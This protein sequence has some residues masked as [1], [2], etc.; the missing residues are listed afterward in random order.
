MPP[1]IYDVVNFRVRMTDGTYGGLISLSLIGLLFQPA[2]IARRQTD[3][4]QKLTSN[5]K[6]DFVSVS[7]RNL[8]LLD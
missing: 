5:D 7:G 2:G 3:L 4:S 8:L 6:A 1:S